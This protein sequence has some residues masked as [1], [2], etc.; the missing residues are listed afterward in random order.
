MWTLLFP[1][2]CATYTITQFPESGP[3]PDPRILIT[4]AFDSNANQIIFLGGEGLKGPD[5]LSSTLYA[6][7]LNTLTWIAIPSKMGFVPQ[8]LK[9][10]KLYFRK[11]DNKV[12]V[13][14]GQTNKGLNT[15][16]YSFDL[17][18]FFWNIE[19]MNGDVMASTIRAAFTQFSFN[20]TEYIAVQGGYSGGGLIDEFYL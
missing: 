2:I 9:D 20:G 11:L 8:G 18:R 4:S 15:V 3:P 5:D 14:G 16:V 13:F 12:F 19:I 1:V 6:F 10:A 7:N 17:K